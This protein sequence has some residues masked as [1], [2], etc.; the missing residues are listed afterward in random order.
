ME[1]IK[2][3]L[4]EISRS[5]WMLLRHD[6]RFLADIINKRWM[7]SSTEPLDGI[8]EDLEEICTQPFYIDWHC[9]KHTRCVVWFFSENDFNKLNTNNNHKSL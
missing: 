2:K 5:D 1:F 8:L 4:K 9:D 3:H 6:T 7:L